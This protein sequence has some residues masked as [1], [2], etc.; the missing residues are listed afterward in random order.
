MADQN[1]QINVKMDDSVMKGV[2]ANAMGVAHSREEF[3]LDFMNIYQWQRT[4]V[5][6]SRV[7]TSPSHMKRIFLALEDNIKKYEAQFG[8][9]QASEGPA[10]DGLGFRTS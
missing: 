3:I 2:Y 6:T 10:S 9:I 8:K 7:I 4:G 5:V 1:Q